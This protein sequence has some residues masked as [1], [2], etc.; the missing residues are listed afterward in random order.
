MLIA[1]KR[2]FRLMAVAIMLAE[3]ALATADLNY[4]NTLTKLALTPTASSPTLFYIVAG[5][6]VAVAVA[7]VTTIWLIRRRLAHSTPSQSS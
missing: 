3:V 2:L 6:L 4:L 1:L 7:L 5:L